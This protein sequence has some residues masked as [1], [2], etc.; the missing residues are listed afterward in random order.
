MTNLTFSRSLALSRCRINPAL[1]EM[2]GRALIA[3]SGESSGYRCVQLDARILD[4]R[5]RLLDRSARREVAFLLRR[6]Q[7]DVSGLDLWIPPTHFGDPV[8]VDR[9]V[10]AVIEAIEFAAE[11]S[12][13]GVGLT[14]LAAGG[15]PAPLGVSV[16]LGPSPA[17][18]VLD[19]LAAACE[20]HS[21]GVCDHFWP[22][23]MGLLV[24]V[25]PDVAL[26]SGV[27][28]GAL[29][30]AIAG[31]SG[32]IGSARISE[33]ARKGFDLSLYYASLDLAGYRGAV[34]VDT[35]QIKLRS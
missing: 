31:V 6:A 11:L 12:G 18:G 1:A 3:W 14:A 19:S 29:N 26:A 5:P 21:A 10:G 28:G 17:A 16:N 32:R 35:E 8:H 27:G 20:R 2:G 4:M 23:R 22:A 13:L 7:L 24:G 9:A 34:V 30:A 15:K 33:P 25:D